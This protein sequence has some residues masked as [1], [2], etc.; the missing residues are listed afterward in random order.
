MGSLRRVFVSWLLL[1][2]VFFL[3]VS[4]AVWLTSRGSNPL[5]PGEYAVAQ[6]TRITGLTLDWYELSLKESGEG[7]ILNIPSHRITTRIS[8]DVQKAT[9]SVAKDGIVL[10]LTTNFE[11]KRG[12]VLFSIIL[13]ALVFSSATT[14]TYFIF[15]GYTLRI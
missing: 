5:P 15:T 3:V 13:A 11:I 7:K 2:L 9:I 8:E 4:G 12:N 1:F 6:V 10:N 14:I